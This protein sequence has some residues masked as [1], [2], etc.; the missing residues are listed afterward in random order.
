M[1]IEKDNQSS[2]NVNFNARKALHPTKYYDPSNTQLQNT[3][4]KK[5]RRQR[6]RRSSQPNIGVIDMDESSKEEE[7]VELASEAEYTLVNT[8][9]LVV[10]Q[11]KNVP[12]EETENAAIEGTKNTAIERPANKSI[13]F[14]NVVTNI[15][16]KN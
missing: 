3:G 11:N 4:G 10:L 14:L 7:N 2:S 6:N 1:S 5:K 8:Q 12:L 13:F 9:E 16:K 15:F